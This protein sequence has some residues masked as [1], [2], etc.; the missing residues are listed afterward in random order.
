MEKKEYLNK[1]KEHENAFDELWIKIVDD[2]NTYLSNNKEKTTISD[3]SQI[4]KFAD[5]LCLSGAWIYD[6]N[7]HKYPKDRGS[8]T[9]KIRKAL[10][11]TC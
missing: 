6:R 8:M 4:E 10:G 3:L 7:N 2:T 1:M 11:F 5:S 9:K